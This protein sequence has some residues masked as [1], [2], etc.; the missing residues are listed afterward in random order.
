MVNQNLQ[1]W[2]E[3]QRKPNK[4]LFLHANIHCIGMVFVE[5]DLRVAKKQQ[6]IHSENCLSV[7]CVRIL[8]V[9]ACPEKLSVRPCVSRNCQSQETFCAPLFV[10]DISFSK[11]FLFACVCS[12][13]VWNSVVDKWFM[14]SKDPLMRFSIVKLLR[15]KQAWN[16][17]ELE[18]RVPQF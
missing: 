7:L 13:F 18:L 4:K 3:M 10:L 8:S 9:R 2:T 6:L 16:P 17:K 14:C 15:A 1:R 12:G 5:S 11:N